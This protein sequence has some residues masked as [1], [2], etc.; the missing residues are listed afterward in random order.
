[1]TIVLTYTNFFSDNQEGDTNFLSFRHSSHRPSTSLKLSPPN[2]SSQTFWKQIE[3]I[4]RDQNVVSPSETV[5]TEHVVS[6]TGD[7]FTRVQNVVSPSKT[8][9]TT[10][11][12]SPTDYIVTRVQNVVSPSKTVTTTHVVSPLTIPIILP[13]LDTT[14]PIVS[15]AH[16]LTTISPKSYGYRTFDIPISSQLTHPTHVVPHTIVMLDGVIETVQPSDIII[17]RDIPSHTI[18]TNEIYEC[19]AELITNRAGLFIFVYLHVCI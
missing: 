1:M 17:K 19:I 4:E 7:A 15:P 2:T 6:P 16:E 11:V 5:T 12:V 18:L 9:T 8:V 14:T 3:D 10:H 13:M